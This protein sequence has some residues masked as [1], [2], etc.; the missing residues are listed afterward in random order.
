MSEKSLKDQFAMAA[1]Q[2][3]LA[4]G[5]YDL[6]YEDV[7]V[8][9]YRQAEV[10][11]AGRKERAIKDLADMGQELDKTP[12]RNATFDEWLKTTCYFPIPGMRAAFEAGQ[13]C[14][15]QWQPIDT[16]HPKHGAVLIRTGWREDAWQTV[17]A[18]LKGKT[19]VICGSSS[20]VHDPKWWVPLPQP[21][22]GGE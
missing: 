14:A 1:M 3:M 20:S 17:V 19:W 13:Q 4:N 12:K 8:R 7:A 22:K 11:L 6:S 15:G 5:N 2:G 21:P 9:A 16:Y 18:A 10:M